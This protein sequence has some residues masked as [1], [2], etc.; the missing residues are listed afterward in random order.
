[1]KLGITVTGGPELVRKLSHLTQE[2]AGEMLEAAVV[3]GALLVANDAKQKAPYLTGNL[4]RS[5]HVGGHA[6]AEMGSAIQSDLTKV[7]VR[8]TKSGRA[9]K[10]FTKQRYIGSTGTDIGGNKHDAHSAE[11]QVGTNVVYAAIQE[12]GGRGITGRGY[13]RGAFDSQKKAV[14]KEV[15]EALGDMLAKL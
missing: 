5:I 10:R 8:M 14:V 15:K 4:R 1:M 6:D 13:L 3:S 7:A 11:V 2:T 9:D 12:Y